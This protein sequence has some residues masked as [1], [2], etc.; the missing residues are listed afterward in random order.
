MGFVS[1]LALVLWEWGV[2]GMKRFLPRVGDQVAGPLAGAGRQ[3][4]AEAGL[5]LGIFEGLNVEFI[6]ESAAP[7]CDVVGLALQVNN[8]SMYI[9]YARNIN[10]VWLDGE[11]VPLQRCGSR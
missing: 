6:Y 3:V 4:L 7:F 1:I 8:V 11:S 2:K 9:K 10:C 5:G